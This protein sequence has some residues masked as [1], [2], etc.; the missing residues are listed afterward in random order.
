MSTKKD[1]SPEEWNVISGA[2]LAA[3]LFITLSDVSD[4]AGIAKEALAVGKAIRHSSQRDVPEIVKALA[5][6]MRSCSERPA[7]PD[8]AT[9][10]RMDTKAALIG[11]IRTA[12]G[13]VERKSPGEVEAYKTLL[14]SVAAKVSQA[15]KEK[16][17][18]GI[19]KTLVS[20]DE[21]EA[22]RQLADVLAATLRRGAARS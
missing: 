2:P 22:L 12:V 18:L 4:P 9:G 21:Q 16:G 10:D 11:A 20:S 17:F 13:A 6:G 19:D 8:V 5:E 1:Y 14:A 15:S 3:G 7:L